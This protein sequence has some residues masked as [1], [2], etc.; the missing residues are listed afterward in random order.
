MEA[1]QYQLGKV[2]LKHF[3]RIFS[4]VR[5]G[6]FVARRFHLNPKP[7]RGGIFRFVGV[8]ASACLSPAQAKA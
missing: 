8:H 4:S 7:L 1:N 3:G 2:G 6:I 5:S